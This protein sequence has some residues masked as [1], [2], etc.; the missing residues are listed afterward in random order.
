MI[1]IVIIITFVTPN[2]KK[3][4]KMRY[5]K[6]EKDGEG[7]GGEERMRG[8]EKGEKVDKEGEVNM[9]RL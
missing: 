3:H 4:M 7:N 1:I 6:Q 5:W 2:I 8:G 9:Q